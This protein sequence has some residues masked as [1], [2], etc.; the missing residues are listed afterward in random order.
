MTIY[1][2]ELTS[3]ASELRRQYE[4]SSRNFS[5]EVE[6]TEKWLTDQKITSH[7]KT[8]LTAPEICLGLHTARIDKQ[9]EGV[10]YVMREA[11]KVLE[12]FKN[13]GGLSSAVGSTDSKDFNLC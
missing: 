7:F 13:T 5:L 10:S 12:T 2:K 4:G 8:R 11:V 6:I 3:D 9:K 1:L